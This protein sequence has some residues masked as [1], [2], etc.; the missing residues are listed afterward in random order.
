MF[1]YFRGILIRGFTEL[2]KNLQT[3]LMVLEL[4]LKGKQVIS[5]FKFLNRFLFALRAESVDGASR[6]V[7][8]IQSLRKKFNWGHWREHDR[9]ELCGPC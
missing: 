9:A 4:M 8:K 7:Q 1:E 3:I 5:L 2:H 6:S